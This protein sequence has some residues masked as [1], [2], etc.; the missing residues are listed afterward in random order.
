[1][2]RKLLKMYLDLDFKCKLT[3]VGLLGA[4]FSGIKWCCV[5]TLERR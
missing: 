4:D 2:V 5:C 3:A 1:M